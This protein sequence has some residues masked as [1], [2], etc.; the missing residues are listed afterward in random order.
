MY[1]MQ[2]NSGDTSSE[3]VKRSRSRLWKKTRRHSINQTTVNRLTVYVHCALLVERQSL[4]VRASV[5]MPYSAPVVIF[6]V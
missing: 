3:Y 1:A 6:A 4:L 2:R 5:S